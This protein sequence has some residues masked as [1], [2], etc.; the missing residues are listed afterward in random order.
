MSDPTD[1]SNA[2]GPADAGAADPSPFR[3][4]AWL[5]AAAV[6]LVVAA[7]AFAAYRF[8]DEQQRTTASVDH[9][10]EVIEKLH[11]IEQGF[12]N[13][14]AGMN[15]ILIAGSASYERRFVEARA[16]TLRDLPE[17]ERLIADNPLQVRRARLLREAIAA[18]FDEWQ[19]AVAHPE[20][21]VQALATEYAPPAVQRNAD[22]VEK[23]DTMIDAERALLDSRHRAAAAAVDQSLWFV[24]GVLLVALGGLAA[25]GF[26]VRQETRRRRKGYVQ[27]SELKLGLETV[28]RH[29]DETNRRFAAMA[30]NV[31]GI[32]YQRTMSP[33]GTISYPFISAGVRELIGLDPEA[34]MADPWVWLHRIHPDDLPRALATMRESAR[35]LAPWSIDARMLHTD[36]RVIWVH[37]EMHTARRDD[38]TVVWDGF[39][40]DITARIR[41]EEDLRAAREAAEASARAKSEFLATMSHEIRTPMNGVLGFTGLLLESKLDDEQR[42]HAETIRDSAR[43]LL[44]LLNDIL[45]YSRIEAGRIEL[46]RTDFAPAAVVDGALS[47]VAEAAHGKG[48]ALAGTVAPGVPAFVI[49]DPHRLRQVLLNLV[50]N[51]IKFTERGRIDVRVGQTETFADG[52]VRLRFEVADTGIGIPAGAQARLFDS[53]TQADSSVARKYG[54]SGLGLSISKR[55]AELMGGDIGVDSKE[56]QGSTF[57]F[58]IRVPRGRAPEE[59]AAVPAIP[60]GRPLRI[61]L[62]DDA[63]MNRRLATFM[64]KSV[65]HAIDAVDGGA[66]ALAAVQRTAY[67]L[68][69][70]DVQMPGIDGYEATA[71]IRSLPGAAGRVPIVAMTANAMAE[72]VRR[73]LDAGM[74]GHIAK[75]IEKAALVAA[76]VRWGNREPAPA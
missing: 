24:A 40:G 38:G 4:A 16:A 37:A 56:G 1:R 25:A 17:L 18:R 36:G 69:L 28:N 10:Y 19:A 58:T 39:M 55:L 66:A 15:G 2:A 3:G 75:P 31:P 63:E 42:R 68:V 49:G 22:I 45:D 70:M 71:R 74:N 20:T 53:F 13:V 50:G 52:S 59:I 60:A 54:G 26:I 23:I 33:D 48:V 43:A 5:G 35:T 57:W 62:V 65:G 44:V 72:D 21:R 8:R 7:V 47:I 46:E 11:D 12:R 67:D 51:A 6:L 32:L 76:V 14:R 64:L 61:L 73:C 9:T 34:V 27:V 30:A 29:I 41:L